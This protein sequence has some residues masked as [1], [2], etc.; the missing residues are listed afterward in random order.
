MLGWARYWNEEP[1]GAYRDN[2]H[3]A[4]LCIQFLRPHVKKGTKLPPLDQF[5]LK[6]SA[7]VKESN[8]LAF[9]AAMRAG[10]AAGK[11]KKR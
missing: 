10:A 2:L 7:A 8:A 6:P 4:M 11:K 1:W 5:M 3:A 9:L